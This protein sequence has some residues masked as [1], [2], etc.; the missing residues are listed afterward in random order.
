MVLSSC[1]RDPLPSEDGVGA[2]LAP[3]APRRARA[4][5]SILDERGVPL[6]S[7]E[8]VAGLVLPRGLDE[9]EELSSE[10]RHVYVSDIPQDRL[11]RYFG[12]R[13]TTVHIDREGSSA[14]YRD[15]IPRGVR[16]GRVRLD[17]TI[18]PSS[19]RGSRVEI[20]ERPPPPPAGVRVSEEQ[21]RRHLDGLNKN[22][23]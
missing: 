23:E 5:E 15:A 19:S 12:P 14:T 17:V 13:L 4:E 6:E 1:G 9:L 2:E 3:P 20:Y 21:I 16:G 18:R 22:R 11:V 7:E 8:R 10:R